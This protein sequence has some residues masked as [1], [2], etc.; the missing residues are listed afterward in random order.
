M[1]AKAP[2]TGAHMNRALFCAVAAKTKWA[3]TR[4]TQHHLRV[5]YDAHK[6]RRDA[7]LED[8]T[9]VARA[10]LDVA[11]HEP[12]DDLLCAAYL[13]ASSSLVA[14]R[15]IKAH[16]SDAAMLA[17]CE[18]DVAQNRS[19]LDANVTPSSG[20][21][22]VLRR[23]AARARRAATPGARALADMPVAPVFVP[24]WLAIFVVT[25]AA[26]RN[27][28]RALKQNWRDRIAQWKKSVTPTRAKPSASAMFAALNSPENDT[29]CDAAF[30]AALRDIEEFTAIFVAP[31]NPDAPAAAACSPTRKKRA[32]PEP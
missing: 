23:D 1:R 2:R 27:V 31:P 24:H 28:L 8:A 29:S 18:A 20:V 5:V 14:P 25:H 7:A 3:A 9:R 11:A 19:V 17:Q 30:N 10:R 21:F 12:L 15:D 32:A 26:V 13:A 22:L 4:G 16:V 6:A